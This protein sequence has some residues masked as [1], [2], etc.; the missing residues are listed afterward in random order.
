MAYLIDRVLGGA[1]MKSHTSMLATKY[2]NFHEKIF[3]E[4]SG[5][6]FKSF[7]CSNVTTTKSLGVIF[8]EISTKNFHENRHTYCQG[9]HKKNPQHRSM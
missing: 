3:V 5:K 9:I 1:G 4:I 7:H 2:A 8:P 6:K